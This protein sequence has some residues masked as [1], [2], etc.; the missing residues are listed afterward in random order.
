MVGIRGAITISIGKTLH[1]HIPGRDFHSKGDWND[2]IAGTH[3][4]ELFQKC[5]GM[6][7]IQLDIGKRVKHTLKTLLNK[8]EKKKQSSM[9]QTF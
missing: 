3:V 2:S 4:S 6:W 9:K 8:A 1:V 7:N 5:M